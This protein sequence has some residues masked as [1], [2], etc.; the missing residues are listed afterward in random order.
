MNGVNDG[1]IGRIITNF[2]GDDNDVD[3]DDVM[4]RGVSE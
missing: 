4:E 2:T 1:Q 3:V